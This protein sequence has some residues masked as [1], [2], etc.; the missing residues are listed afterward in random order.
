MDLRTQFPRSVREQLGGYAHLGRMIDKCRAVLAG[1]AGEYEYPCPMDKRLFEF[2]GLT[3]EGFT[4]A[5]RNGTDPDV[6]EWVLADATVR[7]QEEINGW[8]H[9]MLTLAPDTPEKRAYFERSRDALDSSR[10]DITAWA[11]LLDLDEGRHV[12]QRDTPTPMVKP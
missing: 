3:E 11:D 9:M 2:T 10:T 1:T 7:S 8:N 5:V 12:P 4:E 6:L